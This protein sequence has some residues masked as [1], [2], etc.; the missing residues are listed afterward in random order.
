V[1]GGAAA[2]RE[3][4]R[5]KIA[6]LRFPPSGGAERRALLANLA[7]RDEGVLQGGLYELK[8]QLEGRAV[9]KLGGA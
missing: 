9:A 3:G 2:I 4:G 1:D 6:D 7:R 8:R 5:P